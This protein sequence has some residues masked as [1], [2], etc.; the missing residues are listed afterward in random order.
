MTNAES[1]DEYIDFGVAPYALPEVCEALYR[2]GVKDAFITLN[3][4]DIHIRWKFKPDRFIKSRGLY[5]KLTGQES[6]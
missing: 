4:G 1:K 5:N 2:N 3:D 6:L